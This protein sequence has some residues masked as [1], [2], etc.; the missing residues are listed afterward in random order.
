MDY[1]LVN[2]ELV[3]SREAGVSLNDLGLLRGYGVFDYFRVLRGLP[4]FVQDYLARFERSAKHVGL[5]LPVALGDLEQDVHR[6]IR[7]NKVREAGFQLLLTG[8]DAEDGFTPHRP[9]LILLMRP[10]RPSDPNLYRDGAKLIAHAYLR[11]L[12]E[13]KTTHYPVALSLLPRQRAEGAVDVLYHQNGLVSETARSNI[14][15][16]RQ[17]GTLVTPGRNILLGVTRKKMLGLAGAHYRV[18]EGDL[19]L[20][21]V[22][23]AREVFITSSLKGVMPIVSVEGHSVGSGRPGPVSQHLGELFEAEVEDYLSAVMS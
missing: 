23:A 5:G 7:A 16:V 4:L 10:L 15:I 20:D 3:P 13:A 1:A 22:F 9:T 12:P 6:L 8:G 14:F 17:D 11:N 19:S 2:R 18:L 21:E